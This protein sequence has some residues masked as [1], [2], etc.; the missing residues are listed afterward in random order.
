MRCPLAHLGLVVLFCA[1]AMGCQSTGRSAE[2]P[3]DTLDYC[4]TP[5]PIEKMRNSGAEVVELSIQEDGLVKYTR[6]VDGY[7]Y[8]SQW[9]MTPADK[10]KWFDGLNRDGIAG[11]DKYPQVSREPLATGGRLCAGRELKVRSAGKT[12]RYYWTEGEFPEQ[13]QPVWNRVDAMLAKARTAE[14]RLA[15]GP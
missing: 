5:S 6:T 15:E 2:V 3:P 8:H 11:L 7:R 13:A 10:L 1:L 9:R 4:G 14:Q 12:Y